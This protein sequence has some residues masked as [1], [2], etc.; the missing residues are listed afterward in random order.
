MGWFDDQLRQRK[1]L[2]RQ[3]IE[4]SFQRIAGIV[5]GESAASKI[6]DDRIITKIAVDEILKYYHIKP[7][8]IPKNITEHEEQLDHSLRPHGIMRRMVKLGEDWYKDT[9]G[10]ILAYKHDT[11]EPTALLPNKFKGYH[12]VDRSTGKKQKLTK[13]TALL[14]RPEAYCFY[15]PL[16]Q[17]KI[18]IHDLMAYMGK[19]ISASDIVKIIAAALSVT[20]VGML[21]PRITKALTGPVISG[22]NVRIL[23]SIAVSLFCTAITMQLLETAK[24]L[25]DH[26]IQSKI[27]LSVRA[28]VMMRIMSLPVNFFRKYSAGELA[29]RTTSVNTLCDLLFGVIVG[30]GLTS[31]TSMLYMTQIVHFAPSLAMPSLTIIA[32]TVG[33]TLL[34]SAVQLRVSKKQMEKSA[35]ESGMTYAMICGIQKIKLAGAE[36]RFFARWLHYYSDSAE[37]TYAPPLFLRINSVI[38]LGISLISTII[39]YY[40][41]AK[42]GIDRSTYYAFMAAY[43]A[44]MGAFRSLAGA[45]LSIGRIRPVMEMAEPFL[46]TEPEA[47]DHREIVTELKGRIEL[48]NVCFRYSENAPYIINDL[49]LTIRPGEYVAIVGKSGCGKSTLIRLL[50]GFETPEKG[51]IFYDDKDLSKLELSSLR[52]KVGAVMQNGGT[53][54]GDIYSNISISA[55]TLSLADTWDA[56]EKAGIADD[57]RAMP[58]GMN[59]YISEEQGGISGGQKQRIMIARA[60]APKPKILIFDEATSALDNTTQKKVSEALDNIGCTRIIIAHRLSTIQHCERIL[61]LEDGKIVEDGTYEALMKQGGRFMELVERQRVDE[62]G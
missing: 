59:T 60:I 35:K 9:Y 10:P 5:L 13:R 61:V 18:G 44:V 34:S 56:A 37:L 62:Q 49:S 24:S 4:D 57:I 32:V 15:L 29:S 42:S 14:F 25:L 20:C 52:R 31:L 16:P 51:T 19:C 8:D 23:A 39:L 3:L 50:L 46:K 21:I 36:Q 1:A 28:A 47:S 33:S 54:P 11:G 58:M 48:S 55:P 53:F 38:T 27:S 45:A 2:D 6:S 12:Y 30:T 22:G 26:R 41:T 43:G 40:L 17:R 7:A